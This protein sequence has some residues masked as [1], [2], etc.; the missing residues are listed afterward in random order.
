MT[1][2]PHDTDFPLPGGYHAHLAPGHP[3]AKVARRQ[4]SA[5]HAQGGRVGDVACGACWERAIRDDERIAVLFGLPRVLDVDPDYVDVVAV[6]RACAGQRQALT[7]AERAAAVGRLAQRGY[8]ATRIA[9]RLRMSGGRV[10]ALL[11]AEAS[12]LAGG[13]ADVAEAA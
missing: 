5:H 1:A 4:C 12:R 3:L 11:L 6:E 7:P 2:V 10:R 8:S 13:P 9:R